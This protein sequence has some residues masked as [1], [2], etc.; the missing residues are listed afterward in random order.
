MSEIILLSHA[1]TQAQI[2]G[3]FP[4]NIDLD[5]NISFPVDFTI[6]LN[7][8]ILCSNFLP[9]VKT[10]EHLGV[11]FIIDKNIPVPDYGRWRGLA[12]K[13][14]QSHEKDHLQQWLQDPAANPHGGISYAKL[15]QQ[16]ESWI[17][18]YAG[19]GRVLIITDASVIRMAIL[20]ILQAPLASLFDIDVAPLALIRIV[21]RHKRLIL[22][23]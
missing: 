6:P 7:D 15:Y 16:T 18:N 8:G 23:F 10:A 20:A 17:K 22:K 5:S 19:Q 9:A 11:P 4:G 13:N 2:R 3:Y 14:V 1:K 12:L 21:S